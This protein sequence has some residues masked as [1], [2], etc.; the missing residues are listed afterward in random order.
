ME[1]SALTSSCH[2]AEPRPP[3]REAGAASGEHTWAPFCPPEEGGASELEALFA[4]SDMDRAVRLRMKGPGR[5][6]RAGRMD[7]DE[8]RARVGSGSRNEGAPRWTRP[9]C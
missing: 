4:R 3:A 8:L 5:G 2:R 1:G 6:G 9:H 7:A